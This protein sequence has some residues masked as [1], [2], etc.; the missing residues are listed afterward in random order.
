VITAAHFNRAFIQINAIGESN[1]IRPGKKRLLLGYLAW[2]D[3]ITGYLG[4]FYNRVVLKS[5]PMFE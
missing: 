1:A 4:G 5:G 2:V 3:F